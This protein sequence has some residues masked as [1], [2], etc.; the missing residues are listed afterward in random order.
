MG[1]GFETSWKPLAAA[2]VA[3][4]AV[5]KADTGKFLAKLTNAQRLG[6][7][8]ISPGKGTALVYT[9]D[10]MHRLFFAAEAFELGLANA[11]VVALVDSLW[12][13]RLR[14]I[15]DAAEGAA[16]RPASDDDIV[17][18]MGGIRLMATAVPNINSCTRQQ[19]PDHVAS[20]MKM[21]AMDDPGGMPPR[22]IVVNLSARLRRFHT[23]FARTY[24]DDLAAE[25]R[26]QMA[27]RKT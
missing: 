4:F 3:T 16:M 5:R 22:M 21:G 27:K 26:E 20:W 11:T 13:R 23:E 17:L 2:L 15:F 10:L 8:G 14:K 7:L 1:T 24:M 19:L 18:Y 6:V 12:T 25:R 9:P